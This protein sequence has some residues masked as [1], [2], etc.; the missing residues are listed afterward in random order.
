[1]HEAMAAMKPTGDADK[2][3]AAMMIPHHQGAVDIAKIELTSGKHPALRK[4][5][6]AIVA[7]QEKELSQMRS[8]QRRN[9]S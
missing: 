3:F 5:A 6:K 9:G 8:W 7:A 1:M 2:D 4:M